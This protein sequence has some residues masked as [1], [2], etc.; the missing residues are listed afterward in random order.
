MERSLNIP[1]KI[2]KNKFMQIIGGLIVFG[3]LLWLF[4]VT[5][6]FLWWFWL[7]LFGFLLISIGSNEK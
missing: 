2:S 6:P 4:F 5:L 3:I 7:L 1:Q